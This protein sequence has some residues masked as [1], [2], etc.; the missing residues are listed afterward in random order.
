ML[1][2]SGM[3]VGELAV[4]SGVSRATIYAWKSGWTQPT[5]AGLMAVCYICGSTV[6]DL[7]ETPTTAQ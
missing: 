5:A 7:F 4:L 6:D 2:S 3:R 1:K